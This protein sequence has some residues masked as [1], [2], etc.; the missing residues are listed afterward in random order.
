MRAF[1]YPPADVHTI[2]V[3]DFGY[4]YVPV[5]VKGTHLILPF[6]TGNMVGVSVSSDLFDQMGL[7]ADKS[8]SRLNSAGEDVASLRVADAVDISVFGP[9]NSNPQML[10]FD[11][12]L[13]VDSKNGVK[14]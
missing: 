14:L 12:A 3:G 5:D 6:D 4:P 2:D 10:R 7:A 1:G 9:P 13:W 11:P 8:W